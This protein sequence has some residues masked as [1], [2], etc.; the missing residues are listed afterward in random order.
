MSTQIHAL[1]EK[2]IALEALREM[3]ESAT[4]QEITEELE[5][6]A[7]IRRA[8]VA[9]ATGHVLTHEEVKRRSAAWISR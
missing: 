6:L 2:Q 7:A 1:S 4:L 5:I 9:T 8:E 3:P